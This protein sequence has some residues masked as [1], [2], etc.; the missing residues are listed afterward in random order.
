VSLEEKIICLA[1]RFYSK[2]P[3][4]LFQE[5]KLRQIRQN[6]HEWGPEI[7]ARFENLCDLLLPDWRESE[8]ET[9][10]S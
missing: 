1:D 2:T 5:K 8:C 3:R 4:E 10:V 6:L 9:L 7:L